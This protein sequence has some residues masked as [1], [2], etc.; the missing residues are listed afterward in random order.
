MSLADAAWGE[1][2]GC[3]WVKA[4]PIDQYSY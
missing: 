2:P 3:V 4:K 1:N